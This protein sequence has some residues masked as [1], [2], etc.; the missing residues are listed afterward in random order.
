MADLVITATDVEVENN[1]A[2]TFVR[3]GAAVTQGQVVYRSTADNK[4]Y[5]ADCDASATARAAGIV[6]SNADADNY[7]YILSGTNAKINL[8]ATLAQGEVYVVSDTAGNIMPITDLTS[9][10]YITILG[11]AESTS[12]LR[13]R[14]YDSQITHA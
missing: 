3:F 12:L 8:G 13:L 14:P 10:Q 4:Y 2:G 11:I 9:G 5:L 6:I 1:N 7:G